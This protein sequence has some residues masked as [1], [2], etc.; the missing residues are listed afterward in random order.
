MKQFCSKDLIKIGAEFVLE[1][2]VHKNSHLAIGWL[3]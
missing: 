2:N 1:Q 3:I